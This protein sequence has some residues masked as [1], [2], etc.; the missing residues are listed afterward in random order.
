M[1]M[2]SV[3]NHANTM[4]RPSTMG[5]MTRDM[6][7][8]NRDKGI[9]QRVLDQIYTE[10]EKREDLQKNCEIRISFLEIYK[11]QV[12]DILEGHIQVSPDIAGRKDSSRLHNDSI[13]VGQETPGRPKAKS[14]YAQ[15]LDERVQ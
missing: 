9:I 15:D 14:F 6:M 10:F 8:Q 1:S 3:N 5:K 13:G 2:I 11:E 7:S 4:G 12:T